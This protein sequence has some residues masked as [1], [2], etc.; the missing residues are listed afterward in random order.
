MS[1][2]GL[3]QFGRQYVG[4]NLQEKWSQCEPTLEIREVGATVEGSRISEA[5]VVFREYLEGIPTCNFVE[6]T[7]D[8]VR[9]SIAGVLVSDGSIGVSKTTPTVPAERAVDT[10]EDAT[11]MIGAKVVT[12]ELFVWRLPS[13]D[14]AHLTWHIVLQTGSDEAFGATARGYVDALTGEVLFYGR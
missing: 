9:G 8:P 5:R 1:A 7:M 2:A 3:L 13:S 6:L 12:S 11:D 4:E 10:F 14:E